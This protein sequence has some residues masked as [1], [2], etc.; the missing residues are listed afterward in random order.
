[1]PFGN[2][3]V[4]DIDIFLSPGQRGLTMNVRNFG[5]DVFLDY[6]ARYQL[7]FIPIDNS[8][9]ATVYFKRVELTVTVGIAEKVAKKKLTEAINTI[10]LDNMQGKDGQFEYWLKNLRLSNVAIPSID[11]SSSPSQRGLTMNLKNFGVDV[12][13]D[14]SVRYT[15]LFIPISNSCGVTVNFRRVDLTVTVEIDQFEDTSPK[16]VSRSCSANIGDFNVNFQGNLAWLLNLLKGLFSG[17]IKDI[18][19]SKVCDKV[20]DV[21]SHDAANQLRKIT[22]E[23][24][25]IDTDA[26]KG[27]CLLEG[28]QTNQIPFSPGAIPAWTDNSRMFYLWMTDYVQKTLG[29]A[30]H[31]HGYLQFLISPDRLP[32]QAKSFLNT[33]CPNSACVGSLIPLLAE[34]FPDSLVTLTISSSKAPDFNITSNGFGLTLSGTLDLSTTSASAVVTAN[35]VISLVGTVNIRNNRIVGQVKTF[36]TV[37]ESWKSQIGNV[38]VASINRALDEG[39]TMILIPQL[40]AIADGGVMLPV[41]PDLNFQNPRISYQDNAVIVGSDVQYQGIA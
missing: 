7:W 40:N 23:A 16:L 20:K 6:R 21:I 27:S 31:S 29:Y 26:A 2:V 3:Q 9:G 17:M 37:I 38:D 33:T 25:I 11:M 8:G 18:V 28:R 30:A 14:Y 24:D 36:R 1:H 15:L 35:V 10:R 19:R 41:I 34:K 12:V 22:L 4:P 5:V 13:L 39:M 32:A